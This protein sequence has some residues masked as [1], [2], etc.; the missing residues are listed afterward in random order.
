MMDIQHKLFLIE[1]NFFILIIK[2]NIQ[3]AAR[4]PGDSAVNSRLSEFLDTKDAANAAIASGNA[5][6]MVESYNTIQR[7][8]EQKEGEVKN[9]TQEI[10]DKERGFR[11]GDLE[12]WEQR[13]DEI[14][15]LTEER[16]VFQLELYTL[17]RTKSKLARQLFASGR[18]SI[19]AEGHFVM[20]TNGFGKRR[21]SRR[22]KSTSTGGGYIVRRGKG[23]RKSCVRVVKRKGKDGRMRRMVR[24]RTGK[25]IPLRKGQ[26]VYKTKAMAKKAAAKK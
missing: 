20:K 25:M 17:R 5:P 22:T 7:D 26:R 2:M 4:M 12:D 23:G 10:I 16:T 13:Q 19:N 11:A 18:G 15:T 9:K 21:R 1:I 8:I 3:K 14:D 6:N 24:S